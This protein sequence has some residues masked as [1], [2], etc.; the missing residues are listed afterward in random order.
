MSLL[1]FNIQ[2]LIASLNFT[3]QRKQ[4][5]IWK[6][7]L[8]SA[9]SSSKF[10]NLTDSSF[11]SCQ[12]YNEKNG[13]C[14]G[15]TDDELKQLVESNA[16]SI[17]ALS[18]QTAN[19]IQALSEEVR[20]VSEEVRAVSEENRRGNEELRRAIQSFA[21]QVTA[22]NQQAYQERQELRQAMLGLAN[23]MSSLD[24]DRPTVLRKLNTI[25]AKVDQLL[26]RS[27]SDQN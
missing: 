3:K 11:L 14:D 1:L 17:Q 10:S 7:A 18:D 13:W 2:S 12:F 9:K 16:R 5:R 19:S 27:E 21:D 26:E 4:W 23:L 22:L 15:M 24:S 20:A 25:E 6:A 8:T